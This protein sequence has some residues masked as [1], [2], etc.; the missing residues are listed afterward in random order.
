MAYSE[1]C[2]EKLFP[3]KIEGQ[4]R[5]FVDGNL[6]IQ[7]PGVDS[8]GESHKNYSPIYAY[9]S[10]LLSKQPSFAQEKEVE[11]SKVMA[12]AEQSY[13]AWQKMQKQ[14]SQAAEKYFSSSK[15]S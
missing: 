2:R 12:E 1:F 6:Q 4:I 14:L 15:K 10:P 7:I 9:F 13:Q 11:L 8:Q 5:P 3:H